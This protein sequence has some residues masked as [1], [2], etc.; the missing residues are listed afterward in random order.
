MFETFVGATSGLYFWAGGQLRVGIVG[1]RVSPGSENRA[2]T[3]NLF[4]AWRS[5]AS[6]DIPWGTAL[7]RNGARLCNARAQDFFI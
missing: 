6:Q 7:I 5:A 1:G 2:F 4:H 3:H